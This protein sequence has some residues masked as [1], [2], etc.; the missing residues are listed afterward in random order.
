[1]APTLRA[2]TTARLGASTALMAAP[3]TIQTR[4]GATTTRTTMAAPSITA[5][6]AQTPTPP[7]A[8]DS[9]CAWCAWK[10]G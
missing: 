8:N 6:V 10:R 7:P 1:M 4:V 9:W 3:I 5:R 2:T